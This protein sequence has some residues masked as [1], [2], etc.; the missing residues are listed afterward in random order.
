M[1]TLVAQIVNGLATGSIYALIV[2]GMNLLVL[3]RGV[4]YFSYSHVVVIS[5]AVGWLV[6]QATGGSLVL[7][8]PSFIVTAGI[9][10][11]LTEPLFRPLALRKAFLETVVLALGIGIIITEIMAQF[12]NQGAPIAFPEALTG[13]GAMIGH[14]LISFSLAR[15]YTLLGAVAS[16]IGLLYFLYR[17]RQGRAIRA[18]AQDVVVA[19]FLGIPFKKTG[20]YGFATAGLLAGIVALLVAMSLGSASAELSDG[21]AVK[22]MIL[23]LFAGMGNLKG[24]LISALIMGLAE[25]MALAYLPGRWTEA[26]FFGVIMLVIIWKPQ[27]LFGARS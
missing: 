10:T 3:V 13:G 11:V 7:T 19:R 24:G 5:M 6:L 9:I 18:I 17:H 8:I 21:I 1:E 12:I 15:V 14:G 27:G 4:V 16:V 26:V 20:I 23:M 25:A 22:G 2:L